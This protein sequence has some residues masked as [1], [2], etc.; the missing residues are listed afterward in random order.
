MDTSSQYIGVDEAGRGCLAGPVCAAAVVWDPAVAPVE[1][2]EGRAIFLDPVTNKKVSIADSKKLSEKQRQLSREFIERHAASFGVSMVSAADVDASG[3]VPSTMRAM[4]AAI[5]RVDA[6]R[7]RGVKVDGNYFVPFPGIRHECIVG[8]DH[9]VM[10]IAA[11]SILAKT[12][13]DAYI[14]ASSHAALYEWQS[15]KGYGTAT[16]MRHISTHGLSPEHRVT[17]CGGGSRNNRTR[18]PRDCVLLLENESE[19]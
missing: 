1:V 11:A 15:N 8:G 17:F 6:Q 16:H 9:L 5:A 19:I 14:S 4:H 13:R 12:H 10:V 18:A 7:V 2:R 3:I